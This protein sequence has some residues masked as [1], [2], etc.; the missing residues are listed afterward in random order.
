LTNADDDEQFHLFGTARL[1]DSIASFAADGGLREAASWISL[2]QHIYVSLTT[3]RPLSLNLENYKH[4]SAFISSSDEA[5][6]NRIIFIFASFLTHVFTKDT[7]PLGDEWSRLEAELEAWN[8]TKPWHF[9]PLWVEDEAGSQGEGPF[10][11]ILML[12]PAQGLF[13]IP[14]PVKK[15][16]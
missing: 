9:S 10:P 2:R 16:C 13:P 11:E 15:E 14:K 8:N 3:E 7:E 12:H 5:W 6:A 4:S 1:L